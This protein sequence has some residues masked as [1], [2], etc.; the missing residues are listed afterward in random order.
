MRSLIIA[1]CFLLMMAGR[2]FAQQKPDV[3]I[4]RDG[5]K[6]EGM[7]STISSTEVFYG[8]AD[9]PTNVFKTVPI[10]EVAAILYRDGKVQS[11]EAAST[12]QPS[13]QVSA[14]LSSQSN[15]SDSHIPLTYE[16]PKPTLSPEQ[17][18]MKGKMDGDRYYTRTGG[19]LASSLLSGLF[20]TP[21]WGVITPIAISSTPPPIANWDV[22][23]SGYSSDPNYLQGYKMSVRKKKSRKTWS[24]YAIGAGIW[25]VPLILISTIQ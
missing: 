25:I 16:D 11:F 22:P 2:V 13:T 5:S 23:V 9:M 18:Y 3:I 4:K 24:G 7:V 1:L 10:S 19:A 15:P 21:L 17:L 12:P 6:I 8:T 20:L 14:V